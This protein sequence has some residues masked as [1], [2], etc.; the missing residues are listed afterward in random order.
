MKPGTSFE[1]YIHYVYESLLNSRGEKVQVSKRTTFKLPSGETYEIDVY[2]QFERAGVMHR[3]AI[4]CKDWKGKVSQGEVL[5]FS[6]KIKNISEGITGIIISQNGFQSGAEKVAKRHAILTLEGD[7][8]PTMTDILAEKLLATFIPEDDC[9]GEPF[10]YLAEVEETGEAT[11]SYY[12]QRSGDK[13]LIPLFFS[14]K[15]ADECFDIL[16]TKDK[17]CNYRVFGMPQYKLRTLV[18]LGLMDNLE[19]GLIMFGVDAQ[20][21]FSSI[22][23]DAKGLHDEYLILPVSDEIKNKYL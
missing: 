21:N 9:V 23:F 17:K 14:K 7:S 12:S 4:E 3:V 5:E 22:L 1:D 19:F 15:H 18:S 16:V 2:Y 11:G 6:Q 20:G 10:W 13:M 8:I